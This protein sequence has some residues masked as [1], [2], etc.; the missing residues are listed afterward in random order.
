MISSLIQI[1]FPYVFS[2]MAFP[3]DQIAIYRWVPQIGA[4]DEQPRDV[5]RHGADESSAK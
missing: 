3:F 4:Q 2:H 1:R 5:A